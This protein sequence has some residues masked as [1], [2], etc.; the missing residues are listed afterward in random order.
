L[1]SILRDTDRETGGQGGRE[2]PAGTVD[3]DVHGVLGVRVEGASARDA[4][5]VARQLGPVQGK[6]TR[7]PEIVVRFVERLSLSSPLR[8]LGL[9]DAGF[10]DDAFVVLE[11]AQRAPV[12]AQVGFEQ[13]GSA[14]CEIVCESGVRAV[15]LLVPILNLTALA[16]G[17][18]PVHASA[19]TYGGTG[20]LATGW[21]KG[22]KTETLLAFMAKGGRYVG[23]EWVYVSPDGE[24]LVGLSEPIKVWEWHV[25]DLP[26]YRERIPRG[27]RSRWA[28]IK[29]AQ[30]LERAL[31]DRV[32]RAG[33]GKLA[34]VLPLL[35]RQLYVHVPPKDLFGPDVCDPS[36]PLDKVLLLMSHES[37][38]V[39]V[40][41]VAAKEV[42]ERMVFSLAHERLRF[43]A[44]YNK[45]RFAFPEAAN[46]LIEDVEERERSA[47]TRAV[48][49][50]DAYAVYHP[51]PAPIPALFDSIRPLLDQ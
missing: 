39:R 38:T 35:E 50:K 16:K 8:Y 15:P 9:G 13:I 17:W 44:Y 32:G 30:G 36:G 26:E 41:P 37:D 10:T 2:A 25:P 28:A 12:R 22:G 24:R 3:F 33:G 45:F 43:L 49:D 18:V 48:G 1:T 6:L 46:P 42:A 31:P 11:G 14:R 34:R 19:F 21:A 5:A 29:A 51:F 4:A 7:E 23:D 47:L 40:E 27:D 20:V